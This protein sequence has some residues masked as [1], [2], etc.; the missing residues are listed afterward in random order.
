MLKHSFIALAAFMLSLNS[1]ASEGATDKAPISAPAITET[2]TLN[3][4]SQQAEA[5]SAIPADTN[6]YSHFFRGA[7]KGA[8]VVAYYSL[9]AGEKSVKGSSKITH[10]WGGTKWRFSTEENRDLFAANPEKY[11]PAYGGHCAFAMSKGFEASPRPNSWKIIDGKLYLNNNEKS[12]EIWDRDPAGN[13][14]KA[15]QNWI[16]IANK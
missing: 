13:V 16:E 11:V 1:L 5:L 4:D 6:I 10:E 12:F 14:I 2:T 8:D 9:A 15:N 7:V 3:T